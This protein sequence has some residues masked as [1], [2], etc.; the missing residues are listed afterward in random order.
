MNTFWI[1][2]QMSSKP[3]FPSGGGGFWPSTPCRG[4][5]VSKNPHNWP[6]VHRGL[7]ASQSLANNFNS[8]DMWIVNGNIFFEEGTQWKGPAISLITYGVHLQ[9]YRKDMKRISGLFCE[10]DPHGSP[11]WTWYPPFTKQH[12]FAFA[13]AFRIS[14]GEPGPPGQTWLIYIC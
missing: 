5:I 12:R 3:S 4:W 1:S 6:T 13:P 11:N 9:Q 10:R 8:E 14:F 7:R 2:Q